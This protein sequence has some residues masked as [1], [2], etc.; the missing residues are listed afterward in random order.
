MTRISPIGSEGSE[1]SD[2]LV[3]ICNFFVNCL[4]RLLRPDSD[5]RSRS[6]PERVVT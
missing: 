1:A 2:D 3:G 5:S 6:H 4:G